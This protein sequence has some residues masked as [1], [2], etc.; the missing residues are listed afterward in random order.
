[1]DVAKSDEVGII[2]GGDNCED[3]TVKK[4]PSKNSNRATVYLTPEARLAFTKLRKAFTKTPI[5][6]HFDLKCHIWIKTN[7]SGY[8]INRFLSQLTLNN[9]A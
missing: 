3:K 4:S 9:S 7:V 2:S 8:T 5:F 1:M 6:R